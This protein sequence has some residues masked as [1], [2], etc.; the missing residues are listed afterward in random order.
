MYVRP[1]DLDIPREKWLNVLNSAASN[2]GM[3][4]LPIIC[5]W[6]S[7]LKKWFNSVKTIVFLFVKFILIFVS[8]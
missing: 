6:V 3:H 4:C 8:V 2:L 5:L 7:R 1:C